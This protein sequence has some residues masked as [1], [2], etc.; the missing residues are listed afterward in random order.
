MPVYV[1]CPWDREGCSQTL[2]RNYLLPINSNIEQGKMDKPVAG[3]G[4]NISPTPVPSLDN[5]PAGAGPLG[6]VTSSTAGSTSQGSSDQP[7]P[8]KC[9]TWTT[10]NHQEPTS[11]EVLEFWFV[12][13]HWPHWHLGCMGW[14][15]CLCIYHVLSVYH[16][17]GKYSVKHTPLATSYVCQAWLTSASRGTLST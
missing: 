2:H 13:G 5:A 16:F 4:N 6:M 7:A 9:G 8:L 10:R 3:V 17:L 15:M 11:M 14:S 12:S 1:V